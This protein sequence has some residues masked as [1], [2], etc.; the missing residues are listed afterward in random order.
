M[1]K[2]F[3]EEDHGKKLLKENPGSSFAP[4]TTTLF[5]ETTQRKDAVPPSFG[6]TAVN[7]KPKKKKKKKKKKKTHRQWCDSGAR[8]VKARPLF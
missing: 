8:P 3:F 7:T 4:F 1:Y 6:T 5:K 2:D